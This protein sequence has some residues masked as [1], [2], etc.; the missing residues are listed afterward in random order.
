MRSLLRRAKGEDR[1]AAL[2][3]VAGSLVLLMGMAAFGSDLGWF[4]LNASRVQ[5]AA[6]AAALGGVVWMP[7]DPGQADATALDIALRNGYDDADPDVTVTPAAIPGAPNELEVTVTDVVPTFFA[8]VLGF[9]TMA[10][11]RTARAEYIPPLKLG[12]PSNKFG[13]DPSC[14]GSNVDCAGNFWANIHGRNTDTR[15]GDAYSSFCRD[16][17][18]SVNGCPQSPAYRDTGYLYGVIPNG[19]SFTLE[20][21]DMA[22][23]NETG[24]VAN[25]DP[26]RTGDHNNFCGSMN[27]ACVGPTVV[28]NIFAPDPTPLILTD[29][30][31]AAC[32]KTYA[33]QPQ[34]NPDSDPP[35]AGPP[36]PNWNWDTVCS[37]NT[38]SS[39]DGI[40]VVQ[41]VNTSSDVNTSGLNRY[42]IR[43][44]TG[45]LFGLGDFS[46]FNNSSATQS[47][48]YLAEV[49]DYYAGKTF[50]VELYDPGDSN[51][52][53]DIKLMPPGSSVPYG[54][55]EMST[56]NEVTDT[57][58]APV[59]R[60]PCQFTALNNGGANDYNGKWVKLESV[61][62]P[63]GSYS[64]GWWRIHY[65][66]VGGV[67]DTTTWLAYMIGNPIHLVPS[68]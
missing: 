4:Y 68:P 56:R 2:A 34:V 66:F 20:T 10:I 32:S 45:N 27:P 28:V 61:L 30:G 40:W 31:P 11:S 24:G 25:G 1:G 43:T 38:S 16:L 26:M 29:N 23:H 50:V 62:P 46:M 19:N 9:D 65:N 47:N 15:M 21:L 53:G 8:K 5:R 33:P 37:L 3:L 36:P 67:Q 13:N 59:T 54:S 12:S 49:P 44:D 63:T 51:A 64:G 22:F 58:S 14:Y 41:V 57:W 18:G 7:A 60:T 52:G 39:P 17:S 6:D 55:C 42:S 48:F 35:F